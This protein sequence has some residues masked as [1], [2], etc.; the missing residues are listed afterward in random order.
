MLQCLIPVFLFLPLLHIWSLVDGSR[1]LS[2][3]FKPEQMLFHQPMLQMFQAMMIYLQEMWLVQMKR[4]LPLVVLEIVI[5]RIK[6]C[7]LSLLSILHSLDLCYPPRLVSWKHW[8][9]DSIYSSF[10]F[11]V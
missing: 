4:I 1:K 2:Q 6:Y 3:L 9:T 10:L 5:E 11:Q 7:P 8:L